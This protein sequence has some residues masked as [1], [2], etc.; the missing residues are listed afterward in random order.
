MGGEEVLLYA[1]LTSVIVAGEWSMSRP[2]RYTMRKVTW[3]SLVG[4]ARGGVV[5]KALRY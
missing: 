2:A 3:Y 5:V 1:F 4:V